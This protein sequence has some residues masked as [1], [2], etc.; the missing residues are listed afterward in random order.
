MSCP[1]GI[2]TEHSTNGHLCRAM[3][4]QGMYGKLA[5]LNERTWTMLLFFPSLY[6]AVR[7]APA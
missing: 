5:Q 1:S 2:F 6:P 3:D 4:K 7:R